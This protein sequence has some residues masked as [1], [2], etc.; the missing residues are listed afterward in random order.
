MI[1]VADESDFDAVVSL[2]K[3]CFPGDEA[4]T[5]WFFA[6]QYD[7]HVTLLDEEQGT[8]CAML[9][10]LPY[11]L[12]DV[13]GI[14]PVT[15]IYGACTAPQ[16]RRQH[17]MDRLLMHSFA[18]DEQAGRAASVLIPQEEWLFGFY[19]SFGYRT[20]FYTATN[21]VCRSASEE[22]ASYVRRLTADDIPAMQK[23][24]C[25]QGMYLLRTE[26]DWRRQ[27]CL[28]D[29]LG[30]GVFGYE[31]NGEVTAYAFVWPDGEDKLWAQE[32]SGVDIQPL[33]QAV[34]LQC[35]CT[36]MRITTMENKQKLGCIRYYDDT[37]IE[38]GY[39]NLLFN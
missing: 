20:A 23:L 14:R 17:R 29:A 26:T 6:K 39:F 16:Y 32:A 37:P 8:V 2:W 5:D 10:M 35:S 18:L 12:R 36:Q 34:L 1:R 9:Q 11:Q 33:A 15:Y 13:R 28:F 21:T 4:F 31:R 38:N 30:S 22:D 27:L 25:P 7:P 3:Q 19:D 24:Y